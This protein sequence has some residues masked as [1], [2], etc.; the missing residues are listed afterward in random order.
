MQHLP[1]PKMIYLRGVPSG[2]DGDFLVVNN[3]D[4]LKDAEGRG[5][6]EF[7]PNT[8]S[9]SKEKREAIERDE[10]KHEAD[11]L[12]QE[13]EAALQ[14]AQRDHDL[15]ATQRA[16]EAGLGNPP[17]DTDPDRSTADAEGNTRAGTTGL[18]RAGGEGDGNTTDAPTGEQNPE[19]GGKPTT[20]KGR[21]V[22]G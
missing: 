9:K 10:S 5:F 18:E 20:G 4:E 19:A 16:A 12:R 11:R 2:V 13:G 21:R 8:A 7:D 1:F 3:P 14:Q 22:A 15:Q 6:K 17:K